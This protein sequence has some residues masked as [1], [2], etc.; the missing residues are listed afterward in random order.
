MA[1]DIERIR[2]LRGLGLTYKAA[3][4]TVAAESD[5]L[6]RHLVQ[7]AAV[8]DQLEAAVTRE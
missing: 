2:F 7:L 6:A 3:L 4:Y 8:T 5:G 1:S